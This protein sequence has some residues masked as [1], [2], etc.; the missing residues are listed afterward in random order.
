MTTADERL[1]AI[2]EACMYSCLRGSTTKPW[3][4]TLKMG[5]RPVPANRLTVP[6]ERPTVMRHIAG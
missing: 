1:A 4:P 6:L 5:S 3:H 2:S